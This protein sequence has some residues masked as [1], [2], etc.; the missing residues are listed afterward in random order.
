M[1]KISCG[2]GFAGRSY[3]LRPIV[4]E[5]FE[6][7]GRL[8]EHPRREARRL[9]W[10]CNRSRFWKAAKRW[11]ISFSDGVRR[12]FHALWLRD[13]ALD[14]ETRSPGNG[15]RLITLLD[16]PREVII[17]AAN[18][19]AD[20]ALLLTLAPENKDLTFTANWL[21]ANAYDTP[22]LTNRVGFGTL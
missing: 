19:A 8:Y 20:G 14:A 1:N 10:R 4:Q 16:L 5:G 7:C 17:K 3:K 15:Q 22:R 12:R 6:F 9:P 11:N 13:S 18:V 2:G 21:R